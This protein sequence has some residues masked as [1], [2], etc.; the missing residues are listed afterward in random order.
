MSILVVS[1]SHK[2]TSV[3]HL[4]ELAL[5]APASIKLSDSLLQHECVVEIPVRRQLHTLVDGN[6]SNSQVGD[7]DEFGKGWEPLDGA[8]HHIDGRA[9]AHW[10]SRVTANPQTVTEPAV[11]RQHLVLAGLH[12]G[13]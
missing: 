4:A 7:L 13:A 2:S 12:G 9:S 10:P 5:D 3:A 8:G 11:D 1:V 6:P